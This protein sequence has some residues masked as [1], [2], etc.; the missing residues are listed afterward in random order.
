V[1]GYRK[2]LN[3]LKQ[4]PKY[5]TMAMELL[6]KQDLTPHEGPKDDPAHPAVY[7]TGNLPEKPLGVVEGKIWDLIV[8]RF[9]A[10]FGE[11]ALKQSLKAELNVT[12]TGFLC[13]DY[14][15]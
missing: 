7:P 12:T 5:K 8:H 1:I 6:E 9:F 10:V 11:D 13:V 2:I 4:K 14:G 3:A 15:Y